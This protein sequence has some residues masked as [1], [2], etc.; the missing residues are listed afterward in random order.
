MRNVLACPTRVSSQ[1]RVVNNLPLFP[2]QQV[3]VP[4]VVTV[5]MA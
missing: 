1:L 4:Y 3:C 2:G 5:E